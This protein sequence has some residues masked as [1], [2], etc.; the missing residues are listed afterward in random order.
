MNTRQ[1]LLSAICASALA[2][3]AVA[4]Q[5]EVKLSDWDT[6]NNK[7]ISLAEWD[8]AIEEHDI[9]NNLDENNN[10]IFDIGKAVDSV[11]DYDLSMDLDDGGHIERQE[12][13]VGTFNNLDANDD[14]MLDDTEFS[15]FSSN[16]MNSNLLSSN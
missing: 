4:A 12:F 2:N 13:T 15:E 1:I 6:D 10:G 7:S 14:D 11:V 3:T 8:A 16:L 5:N 9:F